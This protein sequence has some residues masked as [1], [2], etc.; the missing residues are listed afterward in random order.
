MG[1]PVCIENV[2]KVVSQNVF[3]NPQVIDQRLQYKH[4]RNALLFNVCFVF[5]N[6][7]DEAETAIY[8]PVIRK[9]SYIFRSLEVQKQIGSQLLGN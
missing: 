9:L 5:G 4:A 1:V 7:V 8:E 6:G 3:F 2:L